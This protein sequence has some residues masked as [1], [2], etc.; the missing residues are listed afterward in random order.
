M[1]GE[2]EGEDVEGSEGDSA[3]DDDEDGDSK[4]PVP[5]WAR[6]N[7]LREALE[8]QFGVNGNPPMDPEL[9]FPEVVTCS[10]EE[11][12]GNARNERYRRRGS[13]AHWEHD[14]LT[15]EEKNA[16]KYV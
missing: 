4:E 7:L 15:H 11:I 6:G 14:Q 2:E 13:S 10:L 5:D 1:C 9:I 3:T 16:Y 12:F 8:R